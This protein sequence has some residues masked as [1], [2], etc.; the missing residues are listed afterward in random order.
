MCNKIIQRHASEDDDQKALGRAARLQGILAGGM[1]LHS[2]YAGKRTEASVYRMYHTALPLNGL[3][4]PT[5]FEDWCCFYR[6]CDKMPCCKELALGSDMPSQHVFSEMVTRLP[7]PE[8]AAAR[9]MRPAK[10][11]SK[12]AKK[13]A[14]ELQKALFKKM[15]QKN[16]IS[17]SNMAPCAVHPKARGCPWAW[18]EPSQL[19]RR[20]RPLTSEVAGTSCLP[21]IT[22]GGHNA[23]SH[24]DTE[25]YNLW[26]AGLEADQYDLCWLEESSEFPVEA[27]FAEPL[28]AMD[29]TVVWVVLSPLEIGWPISGERLFA[30]ATKN[31]T[32]RN[33]APL[34]PRAVHADFMK[35][36]GARPVV[37]GGIFARLDTHE[38]TKATRDLLADIEGDD[39]APL[40]Q[41]L[42][43]RKRKRLED[44]LSIAAK[45]KSSLGDYV[46]MDI[47]QNPEFRLRCSPVLPRPQSTTRTV[48]VNVA[49]GDDICHVLTRREMAQSMGVPCIDGISVNTQRWKACVD[50]QQFQMKDSAQFRMLGNSI[51]L[52]LLFK[53]MTYIHCHLA[54]LDVLQEFQPKPEDVPV[55]S[56][57]SSPT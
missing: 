52:G 15:V 17:R 7:A 9:A 13:T 34:A 42:L 45:R 50:Q 1:V 2:D 47:S 30:C 51:H 6:F 18:K 24:E 25:T 54:R 16:K 46:C 27:L 14:Y 20:L 56:S 55:P 41:R 40:A 53:W 57:P 8:Y 31:S 43:D 32:V 22:F 19:S 35:F 38:H 33:L 36:Y 12:A 49:T 3:Q 4:L 48:V 39:A 29:Y 21:W 11:A 10:N 44:C 28:R 23:L 37:S 26:L 5:V